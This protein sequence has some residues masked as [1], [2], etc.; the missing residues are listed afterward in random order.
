MNASKEQRV[1]STVPGLTR[2]S[3]VRTCNDVSIAILHPVLIFLGRVP[4]CSLSLKEALRKGGGQ[5]QK[6]R[7]ETGTRRGYVRSLVSAL[8]KVAG[9]ERRSVSLYNK[10]SAGEREVREGRHWDH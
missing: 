6:E 5:K 4:G 10:R 2:L 3:L 8:Y 7:D 9:A 1:G